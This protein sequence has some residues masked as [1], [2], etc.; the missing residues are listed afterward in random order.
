MF[1][2]KVIR[3]TSKFKMAGTSKKRV[4]SEVVRNFNEKLTD[5]YFFVE[6]EGKPVV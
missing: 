1:T 3:G 6:T 5:L 2:R 4:Y